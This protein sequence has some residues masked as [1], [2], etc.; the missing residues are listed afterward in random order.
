LLCN[1]P[2]L[3]A[4]AREIGV[5]TYSGSE[6]EARDQFLP[7]RDR[8]A[9]VSR[10]LDRERID[11]SHA[12]SFEPV[13]LLLPPARQRK[14]PIVLHVHVPSTEAERCYSWAHQVACVVGV[15][16]AAAR[17]FRSDGLRPERLRVI[18]NAVDPE[19][20]AAG[21]ATPLNEKLCRDSQRIVIAII[22]SLIPRKAV[23]VVIRAAAELRLRGRRDFHLLSLG[24]GPELPRLRQLTEQLGIAHLVTFLGRRP[25]PGAVLRDAVDIVVTAARQEAF[26][27][28][29][30]EAGFFGLPVVA[31]DIAPHQESIVPEV[32]GVL[33]APDDPVKFADALTRLMDDPALRRR[34]GDAARER[35][36][37][38]FVIDRYVRA[39]TSLYDDLLAAPRRRYGWLAGTTW[40]PVYSRWV[41]RSLRAKLW[42]A[43]RDPL[44]AR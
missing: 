19:R 24:D 21:D 42:P 17:G 37:D 5:T 31:S 32:T 14:L 7:S 1:A 15:S 20:L 10:L 23:D 28:N 30:L 6:L 43:A 34:I 40:P 33:V 29:V 12:N 35:V 3:A 18:Y 38:H 4:A 44:R 39:F 25:D 26:P 41:W 8:L 27:L 36:R 22:G 2:T 11:L 16:E 9:S 13:K